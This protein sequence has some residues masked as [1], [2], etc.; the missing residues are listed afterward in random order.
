MAN[1]TPADTPY[2]S[3][4][5]IDDIPKTT[6][7][8]LKQDIIT[9]KYLSLVGSLLGLAYTTHPYIC[10]ATS[11]L[12][13]I[14]TSL[15]AQ[16]NKQPSS[17]HYNAVQNVLKYLIGTSDQG[18]CFAHKT[19]T[20]LVNCIGF[21]P[22]PDATFS[23]AKWGHQYTSVPSQ[24]QPPKITDTRSLY[25]HVTYR[26]SGPISWSVFQEART[27]RSSCESEIKS[28]DEATRVT[29]YL[30]HVLSNLNMHDATKTAPVYNDNQ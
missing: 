29:Q 8:N 13:C 2:R 6:L 22:V 24:S 14:A 5:T 26:S 15:L 25:G 10:I 17:G 1:A 23:D 18:I 11:L 20:T 27:S 16:Y 9:A 4:H 21:V 7:H 28:T 30:R 19:N 12:A 3:G